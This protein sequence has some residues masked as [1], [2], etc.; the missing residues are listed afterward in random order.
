MSSLRYRLRAATC[1]LL[2]IAGSAS[3]ESGDWHFE[4]AT[5]KYSEQGRVSVVEPLVRLKRDLS[6]SRSLTG[7]VMFDVITG[8]SPTGASPTNQVQTI[9]SA[10]GNTQQVT[11]GIV[12]V[13]RFRDHR[14]ALNLDYEQ[15]IFRSLKVTAGGEISAETDYASR[16]GTLTFAW[17]TPNR[18]TTLT[19]AVAANFDRINPAGGLRTGLDSV[20][21]P[22][23]PGS[24]RKQGLDGLLGV[25]QVLSPHWL[26]QLNYGQ[27]KETGYLTEPYKVISVLDS[28]GTTV[29][30]RNES[31][32]D[33][34]LRQ[35]VQFSAVGN[36]YEE[37]VIHFSYLFYWDDWGIRSH[38]ADVKYR[39]DLND[40]YYI[41]PHMRYYKQSAVDFFTYGLPQ[42]QPLP[43]YA[44]ADYRYGEMNTFTIGGKIGIPAGAGELNFRLEY[45]LQSGN[46]HP[47]QAIGAQKQYDLFPQID[48]TILQIGYTVDF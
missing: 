39:F 2:A 19:G 43:R 47:P 30:Y 40:G 26:V 9:T 22:T 4:A 37:D 7:K 24:E 23:M 10:S 11:T 36:L 25:T 15:P 28:G 1:A 29:N 12:P 20:G 5:L 45:M 44:T 34:R 31:R 33:N 46:S 38:T 27:T 48:I 35:N 13:K 42:G 3:A 17:D 8:A 18:L 16:G 32:P 14:A 21:A 6:N 41:E